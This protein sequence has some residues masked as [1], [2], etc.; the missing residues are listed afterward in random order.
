MGRLRTFASCDK[1]ELKAGQLPPLLVILR[2]R[3]RARA[4]GVPCPIWSPPAQP[5]P[6]V[7]LPTHPTLTSPHRRQHPAARTRPQ[8][9]RCSAEKAHCSP[10]VRRR[11]GA[12]LVARGGHLHPEGAQSPASVR[13]ANGSAR[14]GNCRPTPRRAA[15]LI[16]SRAAKAKGR[17]E[18]R[19]DR[20][21]AAR[22]ARGF[23]PQVRRQP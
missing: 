15:L 7:S 21:Q 22:P 10:G 20:P 1:R 3:R 11:R 17:Q 13:S 9:A 2:Q 18:R 23:L 12:G 6:P 8:R 14:L 4:G 5:V 19:R 16:D